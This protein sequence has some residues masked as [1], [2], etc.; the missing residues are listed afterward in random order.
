MFL[1]K[2]LSCKRKVLLV[3]VAFSFAKGQVTI[4][5]SFVYLAFEFCQRLN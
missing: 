4:A 2:T 3:K 1:K 5:G